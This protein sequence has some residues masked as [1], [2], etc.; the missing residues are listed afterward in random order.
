MHP[1]QFIE[2]AD[3]TEV[4]LTGVEPVKDKV[5]LFSIPAHGEEQSTLIKPPKELKSIFVLI[6]VRLLI[7]EP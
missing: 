1:F 2:Q 6:A 5:P 7:L 4:A 3:A